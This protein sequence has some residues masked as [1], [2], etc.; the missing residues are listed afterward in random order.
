[1]AFSNAAFADVTFQNVS[2]E[3]ECELTLG[4]H[5]RHEVWRAGGQH[6]VTWSYSEQIVRISPTA[7]IFWVDGPGAQYQG[8]DM[9]YQGSVYYTLTAA[10]RWPDADLVNQGAP[11]YDAEAKVYNEWFHIFATGKINSNMMYD[12]VT[13]EEDNAAFFHPIVHIAREDVYESIETSP[14]P[15]EMQYV[16]VPLSQI[17]N[18]VYMTQ[19]PA[20]SPDTS[21]YD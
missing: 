1:V 20:L 2:Y 6:S 13:F 9:T 5:T 3:H 11:N 14:W 7:F 4:V 8:P 17:Y 21:I 16:W 19:W 12:R 15:F 10:P 18:P